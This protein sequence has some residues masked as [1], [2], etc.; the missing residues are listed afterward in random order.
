M[1]KNDPCLH[2]MI[3]ASIDESG[4]KR[5]TMGARAALVAA[6]SL[7]VSPPI[8]DAPVAAARTTPSGKLGRHR[9][10]IS[11]V[12]GWGLSPN[13]TIGP[14]FHQWSAAARPKCFVE[15]VESYS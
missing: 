5:S 2:C 7:L 6:S 15:G 10:P 4:K 12:V 9:A 3:V 8:I 1:N 11:R 13:E 14:E